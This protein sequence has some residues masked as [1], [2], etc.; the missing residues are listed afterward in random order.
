MPLRALVEE[1]AR[2][3]ETIL[4]GSGLVVQRYTSGMGPLPMPRVL[5][6]GM[7]RGGSSPRR[8]ALLR[9]LTARRGRRIRDVGLTHFSSKD[10]DHGSIATCF[11]C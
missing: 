9:A 5:H 6:V 4:H 7:L 2:H 11:C 1:K 8:T 10:R 3:F